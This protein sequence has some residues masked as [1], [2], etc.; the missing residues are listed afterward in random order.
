MLVSLVL[1]A[2]PSLVAQAYKTRYWVAEI[3]DL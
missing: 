1:G 3:V 2:P